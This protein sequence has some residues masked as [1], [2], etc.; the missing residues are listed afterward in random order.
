MSDGYNTYVFIGDE[1]K[2]T[3]FKNSISFWNFIGFFFKI[4]F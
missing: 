1:L 4:I 3:Q 2:S